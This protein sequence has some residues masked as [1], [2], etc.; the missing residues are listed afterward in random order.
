MKARLDA[1]EKRL[2]EVEDALQKAVRERDEARV[3]QPQ[4]PALPLQTLPDQGAQQLR[5]CCQT[6]VGAISCSHM[7][8]S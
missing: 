4:A 2:Q 6:R 7:R 5:G 8:S 1:A 3:A